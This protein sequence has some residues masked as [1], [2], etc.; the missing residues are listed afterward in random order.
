[1]RVL[2]LADRHVSRAASKA[3]AG[4]VAAGGRLFAT[5]GAGVVDEVNRP[6]EGL[7]ELLGVEEQ[8]LEEAE[9]PPVV[10]AKQD[11][12]LARP[13]DTVAWRTR[14]FGGAEAVLPVLGVRSRITVKGAQVQGKFT[15]KGGGPAVTLRRAGK[16]SALYCAFLPGLTYFWPA[17]PHRPMDR[18]AA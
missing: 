11:L 9:G 17:M 5:A 1:Y 2:Y 3:I 4:W 18:G 6:N 7:R 14:V 16:G 12:P 13:L 15:S 10:F 8:A